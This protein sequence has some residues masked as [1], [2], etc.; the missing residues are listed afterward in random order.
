MFPMNLKSIHYHF[1]YQLQLI[2][3]TLDFNALYMMLT[4]VFQQLC[5]E[6]HGG[7][8]NLMRLF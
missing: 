1:S 8:E 2:F 3:C 4:S 6:T 7:T 5:P